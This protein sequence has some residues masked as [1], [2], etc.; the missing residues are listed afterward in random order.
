MNAGT[1]RE[2][3]KKLRLAVLDLDYLVSIMKGA[4]VL[5]SDNEAGNGSERATDR[6]AG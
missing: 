4:S 6:A 2:P 3:R 5:D 1:V